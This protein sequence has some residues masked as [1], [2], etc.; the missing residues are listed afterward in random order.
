MLSEEKQINPDTPSVPNVVGSQ[1]N[2]R[3][4]L[5]F[6]FTTTG[7]LKEKAIRGAIWSFL[8]N[9]ITQ[10]SSLLRSIILARLLAP[11]D[12]GLMGIALFTLGCLDTFTQ[13][14]YQAALIQRLGEVHDYLDTVFFVT[15]VRGLALAGLLYVV[16]PV[17]AAFFKN[18]QAIPVIQAISLIFLINGLINPAT[19]FFQK[20]LDFKKQF[21]W[22]LSE[23]MTGLITGILLAFLLRN[24]WALVISVLA[25]AV[26]KCALSYVLHPYR[27]RARFRWHQAREL[28]RFGKWIM[29]GTIA[30]FL[31]TN[32]DTAVVGR[33]LGTAAVGFYQLSYRIS[34]LPATGITHIFSSVAFPLY[35][36]VQTEPPK[37]KR[38]FFTGLTITLLIGLPLVIFFLLLGHPATRLILREKWL[39]AVPALQVLSFYGLFRMLAATGGALFHGV[40]HPACDTRMNTFRLVA[41]LVLIYPATRWGGLV[42]AAWAAVVSI[43]MTLPYWLVKTAEFLRIPPF[44]ILYHLLRLCS[45]VVL[46]FGLPLFLLSR[47]VDPESW[48]GFTALCLTSAAIYLGCSYRFQR[49][50]F[51]HLQSA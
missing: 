47:L 4:W 48:M 13:T 34:N 35:S 2:P 39:P 30:G 23:V 45:F 17:A 11:H 29:G 21:I 15:A 26:L 19:V 3:A 22:N 44:A 24:V 16:A 27:P 50:S 36:K 40:G 12:F 46:A 42:G 5:A 8:G 43:G 51:R 37:L 28:T 6:L 32:L 31:S 25:A 9:T 20:E 10:L 1:W 41:L 33:L 18:T 38:I 49:H 7:S 14:G